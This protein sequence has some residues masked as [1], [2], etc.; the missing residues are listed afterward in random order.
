MA[1]FSTSFTLRDAYGRRS[2]KRWYQNAADHATA[3]TQAA[4]FSTALAAITGMQIE[5]YVIGNEVNPGDSVAAGSNKDEGF[6]FSMDLGGG[7]TGALKVPGPVKTAVNADGSI[8][9]TDTDVAA[10]L[11]L[12]TGPGPWTIS[13]QEQPQAVIKGVLDS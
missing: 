9:L 2:N 1:V 8:D 5:R 7:K 6:T 10:F 12:F 3:V 11:A 4:A 13:D